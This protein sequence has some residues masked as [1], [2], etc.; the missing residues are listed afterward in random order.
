MTG[1]SLGVGR[2]K[3]YLSLA[4]GTA[5]SNAHT[6]RRLAVRLWA[7]F[8]QIVRERRKDYLGVWC[9]LDPSRV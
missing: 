4:L 1:G 3:A 9:G 7:L 5:Q 2:T 8:R 6:H